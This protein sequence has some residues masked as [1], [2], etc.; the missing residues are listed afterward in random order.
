MNRV[1]HMA[2]SIKLFFLSIER[3]GNIISSY[4]SRSHIVAMT[5][6]D[7]IYRRMSLTWGVRA[8]FV[9]QFT[10]T[11]QMLAYCREYLVGQGLVASGDSFILTAG[12]PV[13]VTGSTNMIRIETIE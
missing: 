4:R 12:I 8:H 5:P 1:S 10:D 6:S 9:E 2:T 13:G 7:K 3:S 11:D